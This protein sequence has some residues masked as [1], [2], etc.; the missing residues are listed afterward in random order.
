[1]RDLI[2]KYPKTAGLIGTLA[3]AAGAYYG[4]PPSVTQGVLCFV[5]GGC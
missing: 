3:L 1:M 2:K 4:V 5:A